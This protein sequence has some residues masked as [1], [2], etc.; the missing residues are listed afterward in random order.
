MG[1]HRGSKS[2]QAAPETG[3]RREAGIDPVTGMGASNVAFVVGR[4]SAERESVARAVHRFHRGADAA[5]LRI[6]CGSEEAALHQALQSWLAGP[7]GEVSPHLL[8]RL[9][10]GSLY[11]DGIE[12]LGLDT[13][14]KLLELMDQTSRSWSPGN[15][16][17]APGQPWKGQ[18]IAGNERSLQSAV[19]DGR[20]LS[21]LADRLERV[22]IVLDPD[23][24]D[25]R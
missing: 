15:P 10:G 25:A 17:D 8:G 5:F 1:E 7:E 18:V 24:A 14:R 20:L 16:G 12:A 19:K 9:E 11:L 4:S 6:Q 3:S 21:E 23:D 13:Q 2:R 22:R